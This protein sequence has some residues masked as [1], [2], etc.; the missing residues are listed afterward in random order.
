MV[1]TRRLHLQ[2]GCKAS[3]LKRCSIPTS[4]LVRVFTT[5]IRPILEYSC[6]VWHSLPQYPCDVIENIQRRALRII[7]PEFK[8]ADAMSYAGLVTLF[9]R[10]STICEKFSERIC[11]ETS[12]KLHHLV[13]SRHDTDYF[14]RNSNSLDITKY[15]T[16][17]FSNIVLS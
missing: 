17:R 5:C 9:L 6:D 2:K 8:Y 1:S 15:K 4:K 7:F 13:P 11:T 12:H 14:L 10:R 3:V 16:S